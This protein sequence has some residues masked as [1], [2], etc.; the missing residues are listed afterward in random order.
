MARELMDRYDLFVFDWD[1]TLVSMKLLLRAKE[2]LKF[3]VWIRLLHLFGMK[4]SPPKRWP[5]SAEPANLLTLKEH[6]LKNNVLSML[7]DLFLLVSH[8][9]LHNGTVPMLK[10]LKK[11]GKKVAIFT[12]AAEY[13]IL[14][15]LRACGLDG[16]LDIVVSTRK[17][18][19]FKPDPSGLRTIVKRLGVSK[20]RVLYVGDMVDDVLAARYAGVD[21]CAVSD[22]FDDYETLKAS[23]PSYIAK[24]I[25]ELHSM[26]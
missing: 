20:G 22:G 13:R 21:S 18:K 17:I 23:D 26:L 11:R 25:R 8:T 16:Y 5:R 10:A 19:A 12:N 4:P 14:S 9:R 3:K 6:E 7:M 2:F 15:E 1:G 24:S